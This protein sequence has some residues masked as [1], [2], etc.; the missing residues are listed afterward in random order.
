VFRD[1]LSMPTT[2]PAT[3]AAPAF[4]LPRTPIHRSRCTAAA[5]PAGQDPVA[6]LAAAIRAATVDRA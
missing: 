6:R 3:M 4:A 2:T 5:A 1:P